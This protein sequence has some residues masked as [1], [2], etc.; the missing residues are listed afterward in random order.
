MVEER[1]VVIGGNAGGMS[2]AAQARRH[3]R[4]LEI[5][6]FERGAYVSYGS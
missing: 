1:L 6:V 3:S 4:D 5:V 2:A